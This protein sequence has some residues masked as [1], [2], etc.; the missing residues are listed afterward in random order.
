MGVTLRRPASTPHTF[1][2]TV[3]RGLAVLGAAAM[4]VLGIHAPALAAG[5]AGASSAAANGVRRSFEPTCDTAKPGHFSCFA[6][7]RTDVKPVKGLVPAA[8]TPSGYGAADLQS[9]Y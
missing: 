5:A 1:R 4:A 7:R 9:A 3:T 2:Q 8:D 6:L